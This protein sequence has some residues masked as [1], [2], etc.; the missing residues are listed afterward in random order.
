M[1]CCFHREADLSLIL[2]AYFVSCI[3]LFYVFPPTSQGSKDIRKLK[4]AQRL[5]LPGLIGENDY[6][7]HYG[8][9]EDF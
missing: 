9:H 7:Y 8:L 1:L 2:A 6:N 3:S 4:S 5:L